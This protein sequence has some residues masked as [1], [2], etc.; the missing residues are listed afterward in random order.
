MYTI[1]FEGY[2]T[3]RE[4][5]LWNQTDWAKRN[6]EEFPVEDDTIEGFGYFYSID[7]MVKKPLTFIKYIRPNPIF[8]PYYGPVY[9]S[10]LLEFMKDGGYCYPMYD[11]RTYGHY[12]IHD[13]FESSELSDMLSR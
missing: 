1:E 5:S 2:W 8:P 12:D 4:K 13:R 6:Y 9:N 11:G 7:G 10:E 3:D